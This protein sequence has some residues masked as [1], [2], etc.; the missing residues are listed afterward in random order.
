MRWKTNISITDWL[1]PDDWQKWFAWYPV[2]IKN[3]YV[4]LEWVE[5]RYDGDD[6][7]SFKYIVRP[8]VGI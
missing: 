3:E 1:F 7:W 2:K 5:R 6:Q 4:W 8:D